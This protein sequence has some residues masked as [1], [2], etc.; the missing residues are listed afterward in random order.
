MLLYVHT[1]SHTE[2]SSL[3]QEPCMEDAVGMTYNRTWEPTYDHQKSEQ[4]R[5][6]NL[7]I[8]G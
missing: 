8:G 7:L 5:A 2:Q 1:D 4:Q 6:V 3:M